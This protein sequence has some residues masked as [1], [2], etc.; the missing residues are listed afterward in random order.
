MNSFIVENAFTGYRAEI[1]TKNEVPAIGTL[2]RHFRAA[3]ARD[4]VSPTTVTKKAT[5]DRYAVVEFVRGE[6][7]LVCVS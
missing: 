7:C 5:G 6:P 2:R 4:C 3:K 1:H